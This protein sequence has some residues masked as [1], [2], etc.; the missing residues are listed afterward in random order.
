MQAVDDDQDAILDPD[1][2]IFDAHH[3]L[4]DIPA[5]RYL[6]DE[7]LADATCG[8]RIIGSTFVEWKTRYREE[9]PA[10]LRPVGETEFA[11]DCAARASR[12]GNI[13]ACSAIVAFAD[14][15]LGADVEPV[16]A[17]HRAVGGSRFKGVRHI[18]TWDASAEVRGGTVISP[19]GLYRDPRFHEG[20]AMLARSGLSFDAWVFQT[21]L[22]DVAVL[23]DR[24]P[25]LP[26]ALNH[27]GGILG[28]GP[29]RGRCETLFASWRASMRAL[30]RHANVSVKL[31]GLGMIRTGLPFHGRRERP[32]TIELASAW[33][34]WIEAVIEDFGPARCMFESN[35]PVDGASCDYGTLW[36]AFKYI[37]RDL[38]EA[39]K[40]ELFHNTAAAFYRV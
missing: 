19:P 31:G 32:D 29:Y 12:M 5:Q 30:S 18:G 17:G 3:H 11:N 21:Q 1:R 36:N 37:T 13:A 27:C 8:H 15:R 6:L 9:G 26:I 25:D 39:S 7:Y 22:E 23:A 28:I 16:L 35:F 14:L 33:R 34:P 38:P 24:L 4:W 40:T 10:A 2:P 20:C